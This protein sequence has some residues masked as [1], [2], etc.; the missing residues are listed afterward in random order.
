MSDQP[1]LKAQLRTKFRGALVGVAVGDALGFPFEGS[2]HS[3][4]AALGPDALHAFEAH[5]SGYFPPGQYSDNTQLTLASTESLVKK[6][7]FDGAALAEEFLPLWRENSII[8]RSPGC[9]EAIERLL[10]RTADWRSS[11]CEEGRAGNGAAKRAIPFGLWNYD[12]PQRLVEETS[13]AAEITH[14]DRL[15]V[16]GA[17]GVAAAIS[18]GLTHRDLILGEW[19][20]TVGGAVA[21]VSGS[22]AKEIA[23]LPRF[24][25]IPEPEAVT[26]I[27]ARIPSP[28]NRVAVR[29]GDVLPSVLTAFYWFLRSPDD[30]SATVEGCLRSGGAV[31]TI[32]SMGGGISGAFNGEDSIPDSLR[33]T[34]VDRDRILS[35]ADRLYS[36]KEGQRGGGRGGSPRTGST[37]RRS[38]GTPGS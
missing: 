7:G 15:A 22:F 31:D 27:A 29:E 23:E 19:L 38:R 9:S 17:V 25:S 11:G 35:L 37:L 30:W 6:N 10:E 24:L 34:L 4:M 1:T 5:R 13:A 32:A 21:A 3:F 12:E 16:A 8:G 28:E 36:A 18:Y 20:D 26:Q 2:T 14:R 33:G